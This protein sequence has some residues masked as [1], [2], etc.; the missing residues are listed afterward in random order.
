[1]SQSLT[2]TNLTHASASGWSPFSV[3][4]AVQKGLLVLTVATSI[5]SVIP[6]LRLAGGLATRSITLLSSTLDCVKDPA[7]KEHWTNRLASYAKVAIVALGLAGLAAA[8][9]VLLIASLAS[10]IGLQAIEMLR[11]VHKGETGKALAHFAM[12]AIDSLAL[13]AVLAGSWQLIVAASSV[14]AFV[15]FGFAIA[16]YPDFLASIECADLIEPICYLS[17]GLLGIFTAIGSAKYSHRVKTNSRFSLK[18]T[19]EDMLTLFDKNGQPVATIKP[20]ETVSF[21]VPYKDTLQYQTIKAYPGA[22][23]SVIVVPHYE[24]SYLQGVYVN[25]NGQ[26]LNNTKFDA[27]GIDSKEIITPPLSS[28]HYSKLPIG[29]NVVITPERNWSKVK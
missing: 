3:K 22:N 8:S 17:L 4:N 24:G 9:P 28:E 25:Q 11:S 16:T 6:S 20:G 10:D 29:G 19:T 2:L 26:G 12:I 15:M 1:M 27:I 14:N 21:E 5:I 18:N 13:G 23:G 7:A